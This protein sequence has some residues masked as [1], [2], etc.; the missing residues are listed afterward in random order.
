MT[1]VKEGTYTVTVTDAL[2]CSRVFSVYIPGDGSYTGMEQITFEV[3]RFYP[4]PSN[5]NITLELTS[6]FSNAKIAIYDTKGQVVFT[7][8]IAGAIR[9]GYSKEIN[10][11]TLAEGIYVIRVVGDKESF[12]SRL[13]LQK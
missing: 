9:D 11:N 7:S 5:G 10:L 8:T 12:T 3:A 6:Q 4:N 1:D 2:A 13:L